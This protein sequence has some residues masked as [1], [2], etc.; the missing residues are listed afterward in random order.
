MLSEPEEKILAE[1][2]VT[3]REAWVRF[4]TELMGSARYTFDGQELTQS[5]VL[6]KLYDEDRS[7]RQRAAASLTE[8][9]RKHLPI[10]TFIFNTLAADKA[11]DDRLRN[12][13]T[14]I[15]SRNLSNEV[16]DETVEALVEAVTG[17]YD[18]VAP[19]TT[20]S[21]ACSAW[22]SWSTTTATRPFRLRQAGISGMRRARS[23]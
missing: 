3:G 19:I 11:S 15:S 2:S 16:S 13:P 5:A 6:A 4:F 14:W 23:C 22:T 21:A 18:I 20:S 1:K 10:T 9:L 8:G 17:R 7:V 12:Y